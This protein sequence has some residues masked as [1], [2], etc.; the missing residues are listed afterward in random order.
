MVHNDQKKLVLFGA[1][2]IGRSFIAQLFSRSG[3]EVVFVD[4]NEKIIDALNRFRSYKIIIKGIHDKDLTVSN[5]R[6]VLYG[7]PEKV[8]EEL[9]GST[10]VAVSVG[11][12]AIKHIIP[13]VAKGLIERFKNDNHLTLDIIIAEN[14]RNAGAYMQNE[15]KK[16]LPPEYPVNELVGLVEA[17]IGKMVPMVPQ[18][19]TEKDILL[20]YAEPYNMLI[21]DKNAFK[22]PVPE[23]EGLVLKDDMTAWMDRKL[24]IHNLGH[25]A[26]AYF[27]SYK[28]PKS[29]YI[30]EALNDAEVFN[31][32]K[33][34]MLQASNIL[35]A[36]YPDEFTKNDLKKHTEDLLCRFQNKALKDT[37][38]RVGQDRLRKLAPQDRFMGI[39]R[40]AIEKNMMY[41]KIMRAMVYAFFF[42]AKDENGCE[43][44]NDLLFNQ[45]QIQGIKY[46][47]YKVCG[48]NS[49]DEESLFN[50]FEKQYKI[51]E[52][53]IAD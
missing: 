20:V 15:L 31:F 7:N 43:N 21:L 51:V 36:V 39:I 12:N 17:S 25:A 24:F 8:V 41:D 46:T 45:Y 19:V 44:P 26:A 35:H 32:T 29:T 38:L 9:V 2:K 47:L 16:Y 53:N 27:G 52:G 4:I 30:Y 14:M 1:G 11:K 37:I 50:E 48:I 5:V 34:V 40:L 10:I 42:H 23:I 6:G 13:L 33:E 3:F 22:N 28:H 49:A 18:K